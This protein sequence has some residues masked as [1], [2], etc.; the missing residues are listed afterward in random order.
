MVIRNG[1]W[2]NVYSGEIIPATDI[3]IASGRFAYVGP[4]ARH[5]IG[6]DHYGH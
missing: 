3:A 1:R 6:P 2:V 5:A 4:N